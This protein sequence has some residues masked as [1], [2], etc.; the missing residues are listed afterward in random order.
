MSNKHI[1]QKTAKTTYFVDFHKNRPLFRYAS[2]T[3]GR[4]RRAISGARRGARKKNV[5]NVDLDK[6]WYSISYLP[7]SKRLHSYSTWPIPVD[8]PI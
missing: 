1:K 5:R 8:L 7:S 2:G 3:L 6:T 4:A